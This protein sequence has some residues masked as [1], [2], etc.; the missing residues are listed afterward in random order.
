MSPSPAVSFTSPPV[1][2]DLV[3]EGAEVALDELV[4]CIEVEPL[5]EPRVAGDVHEEHG[6]VDLAL[7]ELG[8][9]RGLLDELA[10]PCAARTSPGWSGST[11]GSPRAGARMASSVLAASSAVYAR[12]FSSATALWLARK[13]SR[14]RSSLV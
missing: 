6:H 11:R 12:A 8:R 10:A 13:R 4:E 7:L 9:L 2:Q 1:S 14:R 3:E 5:A